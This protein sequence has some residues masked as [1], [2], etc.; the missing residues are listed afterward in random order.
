MGVE[1][2]VLTG[3]RVARTSP[4]GVR[5]SRP[6]DQPVDVHVR[7]GRIVAVGRDAARAA[8]ARA[9][10]VDLGGRVVVPGLWDAHTHMDQWAL[11]RRRLDV[12]GATSA[13]DAARLVTERL[14][15]GDADEVLVGMGFRDGLWPDLPDV[16]LLDEAAARAGRPGAAV[17]LVSGDVHCAWLSTAAL[18]RYGVPWRADGVL[19]EHEWFAVSARVNVVAPQLLDAWVDESARA[20]AARGVVGVVDL[21]LSDL[22]TAWR[23]RIAGGTRS[24]RVSA[25]VWP[26]HLDR[27]LAE[28]LRTGDVVPGQGD[29]ALLT[30]GPLK[31]ITDGSLNTRTAYCHD[32]YAGLTGP[33]ARGV[34]SVPPDELVPLMA[35]AH[36]HGLRSAIHA[37]GDA[38]STHALDAFA[39]SGATG[40]IEHAQLLSPEDVARFAALGVV[41]SVQP[42]HAMDDRDVA[43]HYWAGRTGRAFVLRA[44]VDAGV[45]L[46]L[47]SDAPVAPLDPWQAIAS[48][49][50]RT[51]DGRE[52]WHPEQ[53][54][55]LDVALGASVR[56]RVEP[57]QVADLAVL[58]ADPWAPGADLRG[59][60]VAATVLAGGWSWSTL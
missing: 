20:A 54:V 38:A 50:D 39:A 3:A 14:A 35:H 40:S 25:G 57:G 30:M 51:R 18:A 27:P 4:D 8:G 28:E 22:L 52:P 2:W 34:L 23:R 32:P 12:S 13:A 41:A 24:L 7:D 58:D 36:R 17:V 15:H 56:S 45:R 5:V 55:D 31:V 49:V 11:F 1:E 43:D 6:A 37:I 53:A 16:A 9:E 48:A 59:T 42:E 47:G 10:R 46:T 29:A 21:E 33:D 19:R 60:P 44:L 26:D